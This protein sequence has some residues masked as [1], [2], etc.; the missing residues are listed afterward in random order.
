MRVSPPHSVHAASGAHPGSYS[1]EPAAT[2][3]GLVRQGHEADHSL[4]SS[5]EDKNG[6]A[7]PSLLVSLHGVVFN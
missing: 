6:G 5:V 3:S 7:I 2:F 1:G 4:Q